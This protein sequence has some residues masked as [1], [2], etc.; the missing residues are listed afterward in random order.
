MELLCG[1]FLKRKVPNHGMKLETLTP[2]SAFGKI[3]K[4]VN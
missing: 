4:G 3:L 2:K 1:Q